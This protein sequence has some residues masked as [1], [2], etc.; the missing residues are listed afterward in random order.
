MRILLGDE[1]SKDDGLLEFAKYCQETSVGQQIKIHG[2]MEIP[3]KF[4]CQ[5]W[6]MSEG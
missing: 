4:S 5:T 3:G 2:D 1:I 6:N